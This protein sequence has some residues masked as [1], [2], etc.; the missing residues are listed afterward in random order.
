V[1]LT[2]MQIAFIIPLGVK[3]DQCHNQITPN[4]M[5]SSLSCAFTGA[6]LL[7]GGWMVVVWSMLETILSLSGLT[8][9]NDL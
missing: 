1:L 5:H 2:D 4:D 3:P 7:F 8:R 6:L 9:T